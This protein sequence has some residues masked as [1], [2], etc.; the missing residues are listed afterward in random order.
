[1]SSSEIRHPVWLTPNLQGMG[2]MLITTVLI[3]MMHTMIKFLAA[4]GLHPFEIGFF[5]TFF[6]FPVVAILFWKYGRVQTGLSRVDFSQIRGAQSSTAPSW[7]MRRFTQ[8]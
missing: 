5:R 1:M 2:W 8:D 4:Q 6:G 3:V 7:V